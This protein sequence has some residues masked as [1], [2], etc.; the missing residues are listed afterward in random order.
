MIRFSQ[1]LSLIALT[2]A[3]ALSPAAGQIALNIGDLPSGQVVTIVCEVTINDPLPP[4]VFAITNQGTF[5][6]NNLAAKVTDDPDSFPLNDA[7]VTSVDAELDFGD[8]PA[9]YPVLLVNDGARH[10]LPF[11]GVTLFLGEVPPDIETDGAPA[12]PADGDQDEDGV[13]LP[14]VFNGNTITDVRVTSSASGL[15]NAWFDWNADGDW[16]DAAEQVATN[17]SVSAGT[18]VVAVAVPNLLAGGRSYARFRL[19]SDSDLTPRGLASNGEVEDYEILLNAAPAIAGV[20]MAQPVTDNSWLAPFSS[21]TI[22]D[23]HSPTQT[24][25]AVILID[26]PARGQLSNLGD[27][28]EGSAG[29]YEMS[30]T[31]GDI[32]LVIQGITF[33]PAPNRVAAGSTETVTFALL[34]DDGYVTTTNVGGSV[35]STSVNDA[36]SI[37]NQLFTVSENSVGG[38]LVGVVSAVD[39]DPATTLTFAV[40]SGDAADAFALDVASGELTVANPAALDFEVTTNYVLTVQVTDDGPGE[41]FNTATMTI[42]V[43]DANDAPTDIVFSGAPVNQSAGV[44]AMVGELS[45]S[46]VDSSSFVYSLVAG[47]GDADNALFSISDS[48]LRANDASAMAAGTYSVRIQADDNSGG[49]LEK[50]FQITVVDTTPPSISIGAPSIAETSAGPVEFVITYGGAD[51]ITL[52]AQDVTVGQTGSAAGSVLVTGSGLNTRSVIITNISGSGSLT[53]SVAAGTASDLATNTAAG[54][55]PSAAV[56][57]NA[58]PSIAANIASFEIGEGD[59]VTNSGT[60]AD[61][62]GNANVSVSASAGNV[63]S[64]VAG[65]WTWYLNAADGPDE[66]QTVVIHAGDGVS[67][68]A[69]SFSL[70]VTNLAPVAISQTVTNLEDVVAN[71]TLT[72]SDAG[73]D[74][75]TNWVIIAGPTNGV[76]SGTLPA[77]IYTPATNYFGSDSFTFAATDSDGAESLPATVLISIIAEND[78]PL[79][80]A[81]NMTR[82]KT[83]RIAKATTASL[84]ENDTDVEGDALVIDSVGNALPLGATVAIAGNFIVYTA[85]ANNAGNGSFAYTVTDG[86]GF[87]TNVVSVVEVNGFPSGAN[88]NSADIAVSGQDFRLS[89]IGVPGHSYRVQFTTNSGVPYVWNEFDPLAVYTASTNGLFL[90]TDVNPQSP[91]RLYRAVRNP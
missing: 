40:V 58:A 85:P 8:A 84:M 68:N 71:L 81:D 17:L 41:L 11:G 78:L 23:L 6:A 89:F 57:V 86:S 16:D 1:L 74:S 75:I 31:P 43:T 44:N 67:T 3:S 69:A 49:T 72:A 61:V 39:P 26:E 4:G 12:A 77:V 62:E 66:S 24:V 28:V 21:A 52:A 56:V 36:P 83:T 79:V 27:F 90:H 15:L 63:S 5:T 54:A 88:P 47:G 82:P 38:A 14:V 37:T 2:L 80:G 53:I 34:L 32:N 65:T 51:A 42:Q 9:T 60:F 76:I 91:W 64:D 48:S 55:G 70:V 50:P 18:N 7:T 59:W 73:N 13:L 29:I 30:G 19:S 20:G 33:I 46:D 22:T 25:S 10:V 35:V 45:C 87:A